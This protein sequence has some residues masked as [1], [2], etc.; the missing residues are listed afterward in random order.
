MKPCFTLALFG[1]LAAASGCGGDDKKAQP[2]S[3]DFAAQT[4]CKDGQ[5]CE[6]VA[7]DAKTT[8]CFAPVIVEGRVVRA[9]APDTGIEGA[10]VMARDENG[11][12]VSFGIAL[13]KADG[14]YSLQVPS[15]RAADG[16]PTV[17][18]LLLRA[19]AADFA[20]FPSG[21]RVAI[22]VDVSAPAKKA[23]G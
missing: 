21:L 5:V 13:S 19:D 1:I 12:P 3:C 14:A 8:S 9:D 23:D 4:G 6:Q 20:T 15:E 17:P 2:T 10:R 11:A 7:G 16:T 22:P 18:D